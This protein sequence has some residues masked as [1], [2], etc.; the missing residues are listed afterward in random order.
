MNIHRF[1]HESKAL[2][3]MLEDS[4]YEGSVVLAVAEKL[5]EMYDRGYEAGMSEGVAQG[6]AYGYS[7]VP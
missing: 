7:E 2:L 3:A 4:D 6:R 1:D 5:E